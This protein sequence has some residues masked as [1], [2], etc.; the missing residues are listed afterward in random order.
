MLRG[1]LAHLE[2]Q[3]MRAES[4]AA[5][6]LED[7]AR[8]NDHLHN[9]R[10]GPGLKLSDL[11]IEQPSKPHKPLFKQTMSRP[12]NTMVSN[13]ITQDMGDKSRFDNTRAIIDMLKNDKKSGTKKFETSRLLDMDMSKRILLGNGDDRDI[14]N[15]NMMIHESPLKYENRPED[16]VTIISSRIETNRG[17]LTCHNTTIE[18]MHSNKKRNRTRDESMRLLHTVQ[19]NKNAST[20]SFRENTEAKDRT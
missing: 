1:Y 7:S 5:E 17:Y 18:L 4:E 19:K 9:E 11:S 12:E 16:D 15:I 14:Q 10:Q 13:D 2:V 20:S 3:K 8:H 6:L